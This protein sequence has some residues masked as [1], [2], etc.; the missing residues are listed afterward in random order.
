MGLKGRGPTAEERRW[1]D[2]VASLGCIVC[3]VHHETFSPAEIHHLDGKT[4]PDAHLMVLPLCH[5]HHRSGRDD[6]FATS[7]HP[8]RVR[9]EARYGTEE[10]LLSIVRGL[11]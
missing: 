1:L 5:L 2:R 11:V 8:Y 7:R 10:H 4:K 6:E 3:K 9:W